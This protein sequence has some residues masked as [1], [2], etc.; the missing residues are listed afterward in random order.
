MRTRICSFVASI[1]LFSLG[2]AGQAHKKPATGTS[3]SNLAAIF[4]E[5]EEALRTGDLD[6]AEKRF[7]K[8]G[9]GEP[10]IG[11][12]LRKPGGGCYAS[13]KLG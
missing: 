10:A 9:G 2:I 5:G 3:S 8:G 11:R 4:R 1:L 12:R 6:V 13:P 7:S